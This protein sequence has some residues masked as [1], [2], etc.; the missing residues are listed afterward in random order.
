MSTGLFPSI[1]CPKTINRRLDGQVITNEEKRYC[2]LLTKEEEESLVWYMKNRS[3]CLQGMNQKAV[4]DVVLKILRTREL[5]NKRGGRTFRQLS[6]AAKNALRTKKVGRSFF[7]MLQTKYPELKKKIP[8]KIDINRGFNVTRDMAIEYLDDLAQEVN[9]TGIGKLEYVGPGIWNGPIDMLRIVVHDETP[10]MINHGDSSHTKTKVFGVSGEKSEV[11]T[12]SNRECITVQP[13]SNLAGETLCTQ[14][15]FLGA[16]LTNHMAPES[17]E[18]IPNLL[19]STNKSG[20][21]DHET[22]LAA[23]KELDRELTKEA[24]ERPVIVIA[25]GHSSCFDEDVLEFLQSVLL[26]LFILH[27][28]T[29]GGTQVHDQ[30]NAKLHSLYADMRVERDKIS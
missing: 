29:S 24:I 8:K 30:M 15:I 12:K 21:T 4:E 17:A 2:S 13:F 16:G 19:V 1:G 11:L 28:D 20:V 5:V 6:A 14:V 25:D 22:L 3:R 9:E 7:L 23:Y 10:Q 26:H 27:P 18:N